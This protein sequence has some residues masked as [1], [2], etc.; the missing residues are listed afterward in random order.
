MVLGLDDRHFLEERANKLLRFAVSA[1]LALIQ[2]YDAVCDLL[3]D[4]GIV[5]GDDKR[6]ARGL[7]DILEDV[8]HDS[9][10]TGIKGAGRLVGKKDKRFHSELARKNDPLLF[11]AGKV[12][13]DVE[14]PVPHLDHLK[15]LGDPLN[16][17]LL[18][19]PDCLQFL[20]DVLVYGKLAIE[21]ERPL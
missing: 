6:H 10:S 15:Q 2:P 17:F 12:F 20:E 8:K 3:N 7:G 14:H 11:T 1:H 9:G 5:R 21:G 19:I 4:T 13:G 16:A 18:R